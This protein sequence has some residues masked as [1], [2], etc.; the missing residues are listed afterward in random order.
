MP[1]LNLQITPPVDEARAQ[2][3]ARAL[4]TITADTLNKRVEVTAV[5]IESLPTTH[6]HIGGRPPSR[7][8]ARL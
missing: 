2:S 3:L 8:T 4:T 6:W 1:T 7:P 5:I